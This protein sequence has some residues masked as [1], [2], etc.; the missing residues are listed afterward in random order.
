MRMFTGS[1]FFN[2]LVTFESGLAKAKMDTVSKAAKGWLGLSREGSVG[3]THL[4]GHDAHP[5]AAL[6][7]PSQ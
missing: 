7:R 3:Q 1:E 2:R 6:E 5:T 4:F